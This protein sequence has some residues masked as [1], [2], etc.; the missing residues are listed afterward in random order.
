M[1]EEC[2]AGYPAVAWGSLGSG[3]T[4]GS[5]EVKRAQR[6]YTTCSSVEQWWRIPI[7]SP[8]LADPCNSDPV[9]PLVQRAFEAKLKHCLFT[10][11]DLEGFKMVPEAW[12]LFYTAQC[13]YTLVL[14]YDCAYV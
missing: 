11:F 13:S 1:S 6:L 12:W 2:A 8:G 9:P 3:A 4:G 14:G 7:S 10:N 5:T